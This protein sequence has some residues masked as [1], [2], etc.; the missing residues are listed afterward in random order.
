MG[1]NELD[2]QML[3]MIG[4]RRWMCGCLVARYQNLVTERESVCVE[5]P[6]PGCLHHRNELLDRNGPLPGGGRLHPRAAGGAFV[7]H[8]V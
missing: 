2:T 8:H 6:A 4:F 7:A 5:V 3:R 1:T